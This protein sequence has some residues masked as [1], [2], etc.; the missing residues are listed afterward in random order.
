M[1]ARHCTEAGLIEKAA[2]LWTKAARRSLARS[3]L[4]EAIDQFMNAL[5]HL[6][7]LPSSPAVRREQ[8]GLQVA[9][10]APLIHVK[11]YAALETK[12]AVER[13]RLSI[14][15][16]ERLFEP[17]EDP[18]LLFVVLWGFW[19]ANYIAFDGDAML[20]LAAQFQALAEKQGTKHLLLIAHRI[21][22]IGL[23]TT[24][25]IANC[26]A[27]F[28]AA[29]AIYNSAEHASLATQFGVDNNVAVLSY[30]ALAFWFLGYPDRALQDA[31]L[32]F[33][34]ARETGHASSLM[35]A[36]AIANGTNVHRGDYVT[37]L[38][39]FD[40]L[41]ALSQ[42]KAALLWNAVGSHYAGLRS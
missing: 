31:N 26:R 14:E 6:D 33:N 28:D 15:Q 17:L 19:T 3:A 1:L 7:R 2:G 39:V 24:G 25:K 21:T 35:F 11:G 36:L 40:E 42:A 34:S 29:L 20:E 5:A 12:T 16:A 13:A 38:T 8:I 30:R 10:I 23:L 18:M 32:A 4:V 22:G 27:S 41:I 37:A 9:I